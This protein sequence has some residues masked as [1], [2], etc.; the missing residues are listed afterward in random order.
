MLLHRPAEGWCPSCDKTSTTRA[1]VRD[2]APL[3]LPCLVARFT[4]PLLDQR[5]SIDVAVGAPG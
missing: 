1:D 4:A 5:R 3:V 2:P